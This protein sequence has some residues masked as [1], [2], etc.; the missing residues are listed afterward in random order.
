MQ[1]GASW[2]H[3]LYCYAEGFV[4]VEETKENENNAILY[5]STYVLYVSSVIFLLEDR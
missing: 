4:R 5:F 3:Y 2:F 1:V